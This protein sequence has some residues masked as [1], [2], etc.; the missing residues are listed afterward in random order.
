MP[1]QLLPQPSAL[2]L[3]PRQLLLVLA[4]AV[5]TAVVLWLARRRGIAVLGHPLPLR[6]P[7]PP[8]G[9]GGQGPPGPP[10][11]PPPELVGP[12]PRV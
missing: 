11:G 2:P 3:P 9:Q 12:D 8:P 7:G 1:M 4:S 5:L 10:Y 6:P